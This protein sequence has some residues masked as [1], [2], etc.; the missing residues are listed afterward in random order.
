MNTPPPLPKPPQAK[1]SW[2][3]YVDM[4][5]VCYVVTS[6]IR[7]IHGVNLNGEA[8]AVHSELFKASENIRQ[9]ID[10]QQEQ[11]DILWEIIEEIKNR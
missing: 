2:K 1:F 3:H 6:W 10:K 5:L 7:Q 9:E 8:K 11:I 4:I